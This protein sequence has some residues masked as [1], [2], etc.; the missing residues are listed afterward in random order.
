M[1]SDKANSNANERIEKRKRG[2]SQEMEAER[3][4]SN[5]SSG[6][7]VLPEFS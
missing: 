2:A 6:M 3:A 4:I 7:L 5:A 1:L